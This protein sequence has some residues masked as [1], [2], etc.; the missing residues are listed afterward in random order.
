MNRAIGR[1]YAVLASGLVL[2]LGFTAYWQLWA[3]P[4]LAAR[5]DKSRR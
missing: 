4:S 5:R 3:E 1:V 2:L